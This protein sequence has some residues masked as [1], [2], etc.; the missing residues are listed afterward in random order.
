VPYLERESAKIFYDDLG[1]GPAILTTHGV[2]EN[3]SYWGWPVRGTV[4]R[5]STAS[6]PT[7][8][9]G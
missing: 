8:P 1:E 3:G 7:P 4:S 6:M 5:S 9:R 2:T